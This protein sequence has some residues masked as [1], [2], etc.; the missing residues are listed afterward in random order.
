MG[1]FVME[2]TRCYNSWFGAHK[3][4]PRY[5]LGPSTFTPDRYVGFKLLELLDRYRLKTYVCDVCIRCGKTIDI[6]SQ[7]TPDKAGS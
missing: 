3:F 1:D 4:E 2:G 6:P 7:I 5:N